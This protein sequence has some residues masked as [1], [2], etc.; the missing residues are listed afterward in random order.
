[1]CQGSWVLRPTGSEQLTSPLM[2]SASETGWCVQATQQ[3]KSLDCSDQNYAWTVWG[4]WW[5]E[6]ANHMA[7]W[8]HGWWHASAKN[9]PRHT[10]IL[11]YWCS[12][13]GQMSSSNL[14]LRVD[15]GRS[16]QEVVRWSIY[17]GWVLKNILFFKSLPEKHSP[18]PFDMVEKGMFSCDV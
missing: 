2:V 8:R 4:E 6:K 14:F 1:M 12:R 5:L 13:S 15:W 3:E 18:Y 10:G 16:L 7:M 17:L 9:A 11:S